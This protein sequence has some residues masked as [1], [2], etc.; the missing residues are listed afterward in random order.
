MSLGIEGIY[1]GFL[2]WMK[3]S[4]LTLTKIRNRRCPRENNTD[5]DYMDDH[6]LL[7]KAPAQAKSQLHNLELRVNLISLYLNSEKNWGNVFKQVG[8][9]STFNGMLQKLAVLFTYVCRNI[10]YRALSQYTYRKGMVS[11]DSLSI[12]WKSYLTDPIYPTPPL[13]QDMTQG[14][15]LSGV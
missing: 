12:K 14:Q 2:L 1:N 13:G 11:I 10:S 5:A 15:F 8:I 4:G 7:A 6:V 9:I 3:K